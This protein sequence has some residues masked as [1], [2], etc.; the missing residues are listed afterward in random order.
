MVSVYYPTMLELLNTGLPPTPDVVGS[1]ATPFVWRRLR[2]F[3]VVL[4]RYNQDDRVSPDKSIGQLTMVIMV[5]NGSSI[6]TL[7]ACRSSRVIQ[8]QNMDSASPTLMPRSLL[9]P[10]GTNLS[11]ARR[12]L[13][14][15]AGSPN[16]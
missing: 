16:A 6:K 15:L 5:P 3:D 8:Q 9:P 2:N 13:A 12:D 11:D 4:I 10:K 1:V 7:S 14:V